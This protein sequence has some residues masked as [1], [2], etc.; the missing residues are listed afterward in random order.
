MTVKPVLDGALVGMAAGDRAAF[1]RIRPL[2]DEMTR[3]RD[4][5][6]DVGNAFAMK[7]AINLPLMV[8][9]VL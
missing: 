5:L 1:D 8:Y 3:R 2:L 4:L 7:L 9:W 6:G